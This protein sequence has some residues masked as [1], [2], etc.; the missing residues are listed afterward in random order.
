[1]RFSVRFLGC[2]VS[3]A[4]ALVIR[5]ALTKAGHFEV[6]PDDAEVHVVNTCA[7]TRE[8]EKKSRKQAHRAARNG[9][10]FVTGCAVNLN[11]GQFAHDDLQTVPGSVDRVAEEIVEALGGQGVGACADDQAPPVAGRTRA[12]L[13]VQNGCDARCAFCIIPTTR[14]EAESRPMERVLDDGRRRLSEGHPELVLT[15]INIGT[16]RDPAGGGDLAALVS[17]A[18]GL[19][20]L[21]RLRISSIEP[22]SVDDALL[23]VM[24][25]TPGVAP[26]LHIPL[27][28]GDARVLTAMRRGYTPGD[29]LDACARARRAV[30]G[31]NITTDVIVG[32]PGETD[33]AFANTV[34][35]IEEAGISRVHVFPYSPRPGT[36]AATLP[37]EV[38]GATRRERATTLR[39]LSER[40]AFDHRDGRLGTEDVVLIERRHDDGS[41]SGLGADYVRFTL[42]PGR[43]GPGE[44]VAVRATGHAGDHLFGEPPA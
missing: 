8:A 21:V 24:A 37:D 39:A 7:L 36:D 2:K 40:R 22:G 15:G 10:T 23:E 12:F 13:K 3:Q 16:Y 25:A 33:G 29:Y 20:G 44:T 27:Q 5:D 26:H 41:R 28:S 11:R 18:A 30:P 31:L 38:D 17:A 43:E 34:A 32:F 35:V 19:P 4:D 9:R 1:M 42:P 14:G 6:S